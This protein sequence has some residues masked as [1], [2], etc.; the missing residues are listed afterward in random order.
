[1]T[2]T[3]YPANVEEIQTY[4]YAT[5]LSEDP[6]TEHVTG[7][8]LNAT[9]VGDQVN[10]LFMHV[11]GNDLVQCDEPVE[12]RNFMRSLT[13]ML[14]S[15]Q[16]N[17]DKSTLDSFAFETDNYVVAVAENAHEIMKTF[18]S[19]PSE[20]QPA[21][22]RTLV[23]LVIWLTGEFM[24]HGFVILCWKGHLY[25]P[26]PVVVKYVPKN[27]DVLFVPGLSATDGEL[28]KIGVPIRRNQRVGFAIEGSEQPFRVLYQER[29]NPSHSFWAPS[30]ITGFYDNRSDGRNT[31]YMVAVESLGSSLSGW[32][33][34]DE[35]II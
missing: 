15:L 28:P 35:L 10:C 6:R 9:S 1:M 33:L 17:G 20:F 30:D 23:N 31:D 29:T 13:G 22:D 3:V 24:N 8:Q 34:I 4:S 5:L 21:I 14:P 19:L 26:A 16:Y 7:F 2:I 12:T 25:M 18:R 11:P 27:D 32:D